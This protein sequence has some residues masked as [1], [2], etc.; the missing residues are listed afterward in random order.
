MRGTAAKR[1]LA[2]TVLGLGLVAVGP[3]AGAL[4]AA[5]TATTHTNTFFFGLSGAN[6]PASCAALVAFPA[7][8]AS[9]DVNGVQHGTQNN[10][11]FWSTETYTGPA[12]LYSL[13]DDGTLASAQYTGHVTEWDGGGQNSPS[14]NNQGEFGTTLSFHGTS[15]TDPLQTLDI[16]ADIH[17]TFNNAGTP[18]A[19]VMHISCSS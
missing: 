5:Q 13:N 6:A 1:L 7:A 4:G 3:A 14:G 10:N 11:G 2:G 18:T 8:I 17:Q 12:T 16:H 15:V 9:N 19:S